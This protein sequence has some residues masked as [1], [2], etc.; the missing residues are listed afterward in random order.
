MHIIYIIRESLKKLKSYYKYGF[1]RLGIPR[2]TVEAAS[3]VKRCVLF[4]LHK[5]IRILGIMDFGKFNFALGDIT[6]FYENLFVLSKNNNTAPIDI[7]I[8]EDINIKTQSAPK[9]DWA[10]ETLRLNPYIGNVFEFKNCQEYNK[11]RIKQLH[12]YVFF[13][14][15]RDQFYGDIRPLYKYYNKNGSLPIMSADKSSFSW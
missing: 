13:P 5:P 1:S 15:R 3:F 10:Y 9:K 14:S 7:C 2:D 8:V 6:I 4:F 11:F 12:E